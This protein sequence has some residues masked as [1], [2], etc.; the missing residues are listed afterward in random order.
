MVSNQSI[1]KD[2]D[3]KDKNKMKDI[4][5][6]L[7]RWGGAIYSK[8]ISTLIDPNNCK[9]LEIYTQQALLNSFQKKQIKWIYDGI[10]ET[11]KEL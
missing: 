5:K 4:Q 9:Q 3:E 11:S 1:S 10:N 2:I 7:R 8:E 6:K